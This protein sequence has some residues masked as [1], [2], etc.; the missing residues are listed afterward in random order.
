MNFSLQGLRYF[1]AVAEEGSVTGAAR[2][3]Y[4]SQP[5]VSG[6]IGQLET[7]LGQQLFVRR[8][9]RGL[10]L[11]PAGE[12]LLPEA[13]ALLAQAE[14]FQAIARALGA[15]LRGTLRTACFV[16]LAPAYFADL[17]AGF[18]CRHPGITIKFREGDQEEIL[19]GIRSGLFELALT[20]D[21]GDLEEFELTVLAEIPPCAVLSEAHPLAR[22]ASVSLRALAPEP[23]ILM[24]LPHS[25]DYFLSL[26]QGLDVRPNLRYLTTSFEMVRALAGNNL[27][28]G[29]L[30]LIPKSSVTYDG[31]AVRAVPIA[32]SMRPLRIICAR[33]PQMPLRRISRA[34]LDF[35]RDYFA[36]AAAVQRQGCGACFRSATSCAATEEELASEPEVSQQKL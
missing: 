10:I 22:E 28:Y 25:R 7:T 27:G 30:N 3:L 11:A 2:R 14:E 33:L 35:T 19:G 32:E 8:P 5:S 16:N 18:Q 17:L 24:D 34:F 4:I 12:R 9:A 23:L 15:E 1:V 26:F 29:L 21:L 31:T 13:R 6:A 36:A 20:F